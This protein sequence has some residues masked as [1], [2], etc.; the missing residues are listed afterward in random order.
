MHL[1]R[2]THSDFVLTFECS[3]FQQRWEKGVKLLKGA[4][5]LTSTYSCSDEAEVKHLTPYNEDKADD[6]GAIQLGNPNEGAFFFEQ[7]IIAFG[8]SL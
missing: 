8:L 7:Q 5:H 6:I 4:H 2:V 1:L 3:K